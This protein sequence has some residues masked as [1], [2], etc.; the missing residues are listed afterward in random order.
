MIKVIK[1]ASIFQPVTIAVCGCGS[2]PVTIALCMMSVTSGQ[3]I[4]VCFALLI[5]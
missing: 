3:F 5:T 4:L 1:V 2:M